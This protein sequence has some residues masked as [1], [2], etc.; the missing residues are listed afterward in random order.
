M[1]LDAE[2]SLRRMRTAR[3]IAIIAILALASFFGSTPP[4]SAD[5]GQHVG[6]VNHFLRSAQE[7]D[8]QTEVTLP[9]FRGTSNN[10]TV[11]YVM[12]ESS[13]RG[14]ANSHGI[15]YAPKLVNAKGTAAVQIVT[16]TAGVIEFP[17]TVDFGPTR[18][19]TPGPSGFPPDAVAPPAVG[20]EAY[21]PLIQL[22]DG[23]VLN[24]PQVANSTG[25]AD[26]VVS[27]D[28][29]GMKV[30]YRET[31]GRYDNRVVHYVSFDS[32]GLVA[33]AL[34]DVTYAPNLGTSPSNAANDHNS[35]REGLIAF[36]N[37]QTGLNN[38]NRQGLNS[39]ILDGAFPLNILEEIPEGQA[40]PGFPAYSP[41]WDVHLAQWTAAAVAAGDNTRQ[42]DFGTVIALSDVGTFPSGARPLQ[43]AGFTVN[44]PAVS[45][46][47]G[48]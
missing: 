48:K 7:N 10:D 29:A 32:S 35:A 26:K 20:D 31:E 3:A 47:P 13:D 17:G 24:A 39:A 43:A 46:N 41:L 18:S 6:S 22:P 44:C 1:R 28:T 2:M 30:V 27:L 11:W 34:E 38:P 5:L 4:A 40:D 12:T 9:L 33:A 45:L 36:T 19:V 8:T 25:R 42:A 15:N 23:M 37:G 14:F 21:S 16:V